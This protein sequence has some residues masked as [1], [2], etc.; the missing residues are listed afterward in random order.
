MSPF[1]RDALRLYSTLALMTPEGMSA[2][3]YDRLEADM[4]RFSDLL[5]R[6]YIG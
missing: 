4:E 2:E 3:V 1:Y 6:T 5:A